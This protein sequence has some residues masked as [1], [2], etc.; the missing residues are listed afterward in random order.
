[1]ST[2][3]MPQPE[4][5]RA[6]R[7]AFVLL[8]MGFI[9]FMSAQTSSG[10]QSMAIVQVL[11]HLV[12]V[13]PDAAGLA[14][15]NHLLRKTAHFSVYATLALLSWWALPGRGW[16]RFVGAWAIAALYAC[17]D[18]FHQ[19]FVPSRGP[20]PWDVALDSTGAGCAMLLAALLTRRK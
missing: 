13:Q 5:P 19:A 12:G 15:A 6:W 10:D 11:L 4:Q 18:E 20:S 3:T 16:R 1:M 9:F 17:T 8:W 7:W 2:Q 14:L